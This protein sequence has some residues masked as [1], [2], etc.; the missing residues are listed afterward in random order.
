MKVGDM[1][2]LQII[3]TVLPEEAETF[4]RGIIV[5]MHEICYHQMVGEVLM[6]E[7]DILWAHGEI[8]AGVPVRI[9]A[10]VADDETSHDDDLLADSLIRALGFPIY[11]AIVGH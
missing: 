2:Q 11:P 6:E 10:Q 3:E 1:V 7:A 8:S 9:L 4:S 5:A